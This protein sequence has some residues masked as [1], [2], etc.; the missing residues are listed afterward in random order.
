[1][2]GEL[3]TAVHQFLPT[4]AGGDAI[5]NHVL[6]LQR[7]LRSAG[8][9]SEIFADEVKPAV[10]RHARHYREFS[11]ADGPPPW[12][13]YHLSTGSPMAGFLA[14]QAERC[15]LAV[16]Y[17]NIT[18]AK[19]FERWEPEA[20]KS[21]RGA[22]DELRRLAAV[23][24]LAMA[25]STHSADELAAEGYPDPQVVPVLVD[26]SEYDAPSDASATARLQ[27][28]ARDGGAHWLFVG[29]L[30]PNKCQHDVIAAFAA[31]RA[32]FDPAARL[33]LIGGKTSELYHRA[34]ELLVSELGVEGSVD[35]ADHV[36][37]AELLAYYRSASVFVS[38]SQHEGF[39][40]PVL[41]AMHV[42]IPVVA[43]AA[44]AVP[45][46]VGDGGLLLPGSDPLLVATAVDR[47]LSDAP[48]RERLVASGRERTE[49][50]SLAHS[51]RRFL[52]VL[53][54]R[55]VTAGG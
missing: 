15:P 7:V 43:L 3:G 24:R 22:R 17:H 33:S 53:A 5:G 38:L 47:V 32:V 20:A 46:T 40:V 51:G 50:Y 34:L 35:F 28:A 52:D 48:L 41:E 27:R 1:M 42:G 18:P 16:Y 14:E 12:L 39:C 13:L 29:R 45:E 2:S 6:R 54:S 55:E 30:A 37:F 11:P 21:V 23:T 4:F 26:F 19:F 36:T 25:N 44:S 9:E 31:H 8:F 49:C 10:R